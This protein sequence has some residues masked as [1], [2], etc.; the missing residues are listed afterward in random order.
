M[1]PLRCHL[2]FDLFTAR[3]NETLGERI[4]SAHDCKTDKNSKK[5][6]NSSRNWT[7]SLLCSASAS[8]P[9]PTSEVSLVKRCHMMCHV[10][11]YQSLKVTITSSKKE[12][13]K[14]KKKHKQKKAAELHV[15]PGC[16]P[17]SRWGPPP[18]SPLIPPPRFSLC[19]NL[20]RSSPH[21]LNS[22]LSFLVL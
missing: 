6:E 4:E 2:C 15:S 3:H 9:L 14:S 18:P 21:H 10:K 1:Q 11:N 12:K 22:A 19:R 17:T 16:Q 13:N 8:A 20:T 5:F 7:D